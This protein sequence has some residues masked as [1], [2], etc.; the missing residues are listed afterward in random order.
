MAVPVI[1][2]SLMALPDLRMLRHRVGLVRFL[3][4]IIDSGNLYPRKLIFL[5]QEKSVL[6]HRYIYAFKEI[7]DESPILVPAHEFIPRVSSNTSV[8]IDLK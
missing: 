4:C 2:Q 3:T 5:S 7:S 1:L 6:P 8:I